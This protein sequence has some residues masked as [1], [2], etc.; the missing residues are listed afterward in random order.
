MDA[1]TLLANHANGSRRTSVLQT[2]DESVSVRAK[3]YEDDERTILQI[4]AW[5]A[6]LGHYLHAYFDAETGALLVSTTGTQ[7]QDAYERAANE[8]TRRGISLSSS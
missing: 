8:L 1:K 6:D 2:D 7:D 4:R 3:V 5:V